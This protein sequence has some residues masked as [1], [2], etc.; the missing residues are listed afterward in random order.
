MAGTLGQ[1]SA[2]GSRV[3]SGTPKC[4]PFVSGLLSELFHMLPRHLGEWKYDV[5][6][7]VLQENGSCYVRALRKRAPAT[8]RKKS[9]WGIFR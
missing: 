6:V 5:S 4:S 8:E 7:L 9:R 1:V 3:V 2:L